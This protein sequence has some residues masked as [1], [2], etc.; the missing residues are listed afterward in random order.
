MLYVRGHLDPVEVKIETEHE[1]VGVVLNKLEKKLHIYLV[2]RPP[3]HSVESYSVQQCKYYYYKQ[4]L[5]SC[6]RLQLFS[7]LENTDCC[8]GEYVVIRF[9]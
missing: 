2:Y 3:H 7:Q 8:C 6:W 9:Y 5:H 4:I 1:I